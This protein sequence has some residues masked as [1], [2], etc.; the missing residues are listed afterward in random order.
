MLVEYERTG[1]HFFFKKATNIVPLGSLY[2]L[3]NVYVQ[4][5]HYQIRCFKQKVFRDGNIEK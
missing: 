1:L 3:Y 5:K 2:I 4:S